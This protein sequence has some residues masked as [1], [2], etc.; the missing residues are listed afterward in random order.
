MVGKC[1]KNVWGTISE[2]PGGIVKRLFGGLSEAPR[3]VWQEKAWHVTTKNATT[4]MLEI[5]KPRESTFN[6]LETDNSDKTFNAGVVF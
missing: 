4:L 1:Q 3:K 2:G 5:S 6:K